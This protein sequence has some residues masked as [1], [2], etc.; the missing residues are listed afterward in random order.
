[1]KPD[2]T[3]PAMSGVRPCAPFAVILNTADH[4]AP[5]LYSRHGQRAEVIGINRRSLEPACGFRVHLRFADGTEWAD[6]S[7]H[8]RAADL[9]AVPE[10][11][12][13]SER[14][15]LAW[16]L[17]TARDKAHE[18]M[19]DDHDRECTEIRTLPTGG[20]GNALVGRASYEQEMRFRRERIRAGVP[21][22]LPTWESL[23][24]YWKAG[25]SGEG[26]AS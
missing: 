4:V 18:T 12:R 2:P 24:V 21:F 9:S 25:Q 11:H 16:L 26:G 7:D 8:L 5:A 1:M 15:A 19:R 14:L 6:F 23:A 22:D 17:T 20:D 10:T 13:G 3:S